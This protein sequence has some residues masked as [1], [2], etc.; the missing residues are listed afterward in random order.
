MSQRETILNVTGMTCGA[1][2]RHVGGAL[3]SVPG[4]VD[5]EVDLRAGR[6]RVVTGEDVEV[7]SLVAA[8]E[9]AG[10]EARP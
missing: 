1:C 8:I 5:V 3:R 10:Y 2:V 4:V 6:A 9:D 7:A